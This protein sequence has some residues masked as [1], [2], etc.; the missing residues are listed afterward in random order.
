MQ[1][2]VQPRQQGTCDETASGCIFLGDF[3]WM[4]PNRSGSVKSVREF[5]KA[6]PSAAAFTSSFGVCFLLGFVLGIFLEE[7]QAL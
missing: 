5:L 4:P 6:G 1:R 2:W 7:V 3:R